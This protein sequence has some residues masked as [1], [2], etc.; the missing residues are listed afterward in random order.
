MVST[1]D[2]SI[3]SV[4]HIRDIEIVIPLN[5]HDMDLRKVI[6]RQLDGLS[7]MIII[8]YRCFSFFF[9]AKVNTVIPTDSTVM[10][11]QTLLFTVAVIFWF[12]FN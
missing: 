10:L 11:L 5:M 8:V 4:L 6:E 7:I 3:D 12:C 9:L 1:D 2:P